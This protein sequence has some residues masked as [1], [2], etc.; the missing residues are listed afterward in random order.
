MATE[1]FGSTEGWV[2]G[3]PQRKQID[4]QMLSHQRSRNLMLLFF[5]FLLKRHILEICVFE[6]LVNRLL[7][8]VNLHQGCRKRK[9]YFSFVRLLPHKTCVCTTCGACFFL[10][11]VVL[12]VCVLG[13]LSF[14]SFA[15][16]RASYAFCCAL[17]H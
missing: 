14:Q 12:C 15:R 6:Y 16:R 1:R 2:D 7:C 8:V 11:K 10:S 17:S 13:K 9:V 3:T 5:Y 4:Y